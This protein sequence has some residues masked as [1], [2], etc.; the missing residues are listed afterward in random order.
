[1]PESRVTPI[2]PAHYLKG[3]PMNSSEE[4]YTGDLVVIRRG[5]RRRWNQHC[6]LDGLRPNANRDFV[7]TEVYEPKSVLVATELHGQWLTYDDGHGGF[8]VA[9]GMWFRHA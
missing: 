2:A 4:F 7:V 9:N 6:K 8:G 1:M 3:R 5:F